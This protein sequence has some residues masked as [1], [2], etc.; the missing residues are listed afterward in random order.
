MHGEVITVFILCI[1]RTWLPYRLL[2][3]VC[4]ILDVYSNKE[5]SLHR[6]AWVSTLPVTAKDTWLS[7]NTVQFVHIKRMV[8]LHVVSKRLPT[9]LESGFESRLGSE[10]SGFNMWHFLK[11]VV[12]VFPGYSGFIPSFIGYWFQ[13]MKKK[14]LKYTRFQFCQT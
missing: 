5:S 3:V 8:T 14:K 1:W 4:A 7:Y 11:L 12:R 13:P 2:L 9:T 10:S 6:R